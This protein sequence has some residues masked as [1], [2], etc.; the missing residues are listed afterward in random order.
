MDHYAVKALED[1]SVF[2]IVIG[3]CEIFK[4]E[5]ICFLADG[6][7]SLI[8]SLLG[9]EPDAMAAVLIALDVFPFQSQNIADAEAGEAG[10]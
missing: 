2:R 10:E 4:A 8:V 7:R 9:A 6:K 3:I 5:F 1:R